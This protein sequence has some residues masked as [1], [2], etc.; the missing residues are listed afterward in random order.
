M[1]KSGKTLKIKRI[2][3][4]CACAESNVAMKKE[5]F[6]SPHSAVRTRAWK[7]VHSTHCTV[8]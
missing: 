3:R 5:G 4:K 8:L 6:F 1:L 2:Q 7:A